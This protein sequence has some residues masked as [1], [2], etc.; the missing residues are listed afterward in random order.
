MM[1]SLRDRPAFTLAVLL[2]LG[3]AGFNAFMVTLMALRLE[4]LLPGPFAEMTHFTEAQHRIHDL[5]FGF[6]F[7][8]TVAGI[9]AQLRRPSKNVAGQLMALVPVVGLLLALAL[10]F[11]ISRNTNSLQPPWVMV[12][13]AALIAIALHPAGSDFFRSFGL[14]RINWA[15]LTLVIMAAIPLLL[16]AVDNVRRQG[17]VTNEHAGMGHY[18]FMAAFAFTVIGTGLL[19]SLRPD[20]WW[21][22]AWVAGLLPAFLGLTSLV[23]PNADSSLGTVRALALIVWGVAFVASAEL[24]QKAASPTLLGSWGLVPKRERD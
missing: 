13:L 24:T 22:T 17:A 12:G 11:A 19:A 2:T 21:L 10:T 15:M 23:Y 16:F 7:V 8:P 3:L 4:F 9:V 1:H 6:I 5:T 20:G 14:G 18:G